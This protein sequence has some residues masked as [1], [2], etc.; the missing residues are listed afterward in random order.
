MIYQIAVPPKGGKG[1]IGIYPSWENDGA[2]DEQILIKQ[3]DFSILFT[4]NYSGQFCRRIEKQLLRYGQF[5]DIVCGWE[6]EK[7]RMLFLPLN[8]SIEVFP[9]SAMHFNTFDLI[10]QVQQQRTRKTKNKK[11][12]IFFAVSDRPDRLK[13]VNLMVQILA[14]TNRPLRVVGYG[15][16]SE[17]TQREIKRNPRLFFSWQGKAAVND[18]QERLKFLTDLAQSCCLLVTSRAEGYSR[19]IGEAL[20]LGVPVLLYAEIL[21]E[22]WPHLNSNNCRMFTE[23]TFN[24][25]LNDILARDWDFP[26]PEYPDGN[27]M[28]RKYFEDYLSCRGFPKPDIWYPLSYGGQTKHRVTLEQ[29]K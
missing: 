3:R 12:D 21:C 8:P 28:L 7:L 11:H 29:S 19:L 17:T 2:E 4:K 5:V 23:A 20:L 9:L 10:S 27:R 26:P 16:I 25:C 24:S 22:N 13:Q 18:T 1:L 6:P 14:K 15:R